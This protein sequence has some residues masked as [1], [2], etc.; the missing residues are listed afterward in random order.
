MREAAGKAVSAALDLFTKSYL[1]VR[2]S[3]PASLRA[4]AQFC[5]SPSL[6]QEVPFIRDKWESVDLC[7][8]MTPLR[9]WQ[10]QCLIAARF[11]PE[12]DAILYNVTIHCTHAGEKRDLEMLCSIGTLAGKLWL[13]QRRFKALEEFIQ[14]ELKKKN[15]LCI[16]SLSLQLQLMLFISRIYRLQAVPRSYRI[17]KLPPDFEADVSEDLSLLTSLTKQS[18][19]DRFWTMGVFKV[20][21]TQYFNK[22]PLSATV[23]PQCPERLR[24]IAKEFVQKHKSA[25]QCSGSQVA[26]RNIQA[27][28]NDMTTS[29][30]GIVRACNRAGMFEERTAWL[31]FL[32]EHS[33][34]APTAN[35]VDESTMTDFVQ[36]MDIV[37]PTIQSLLGEWPPIT[38]RPLWEEVLGFPYVLVD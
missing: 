7:L 34:R 2:G 3:Y 38:I 31:N 15:G 17:V 33:L 6:V 12:A 32:D 37:A 11:F 23:Y 10:V 25:L 16:G 13:S 20:L 8:F 29:I 18:A 22:L 1:E 4:L 36:I 35:F 5:V 19:V 9:I 28:L 14:Q 24:G 21:E 27:V 30:H 26:V